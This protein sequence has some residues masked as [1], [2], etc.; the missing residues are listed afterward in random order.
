MQ[1]IMKMYEVVPEKNASQ[2]DVYRDDWDQFT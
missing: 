2:V 1:E